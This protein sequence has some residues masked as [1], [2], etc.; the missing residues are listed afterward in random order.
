MCVQVEHCITLEGTTY[1]GFCNRYNI[2][3][4]LQCPT[5]A[6][7]NMRAVSLFLLGY[8]YAHHFGE[9]IKNC[10]SRHIQLGLITVFCPLRVTKHFEHL[11]P[12]PWKSAS[13]VISKSQHL[14]GSCNHWRNQLHSLLIL[15]CNLHWVS[16]SFCHAPL[17]AWLGSGSPRPGWELGKSNVYSSELPPQW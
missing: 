2:L 13:W 14:P 16:M 15:P 12:F 7:P 4:V 10:Q 8:Y 3:K 9:G 17:Q 1:P 6:T 11:T 5:C